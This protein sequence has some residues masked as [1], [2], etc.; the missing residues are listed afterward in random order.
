MGFASE[1][2]IHTLYSLKST[3]EAALATLKRENEQLRVAAS[4][5]GHRLKNVVAVIQS[6]ARQTIRQSTTMDDFEA[7]F[8]G[9]LGAFGRSLDL[10]IANDWHGARLD[11]LVRLELATF[12]SLAG[13]QISV[14]GPPLHLKPEA[15]R[16]I[17]LALHELA[18]NATKYGAL[19]VPEGK[20]A[21]QWKLA[22][23]GSHRRLLMTWQESGG[24]I[25]T[26]PTRW[27]F[28]RQV[29][30]QI[31]AQALT[32]NVTH[33]FLPHG[34]R[35]ALDI[36]VTFVIDARSKSANVS[37]YIG[38]TRNEMDQHVSQ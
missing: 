27:G 21:V 24:P 30:Q 19:S 23:N 31:P 12:G 34:V 20:V 8:S 29:I 37:P 16:S 13:A 26:E 28:G 11:E 10:L 22:G 1:A 14:K 15:A 25:V 4:E 6:L 5:L 38:S 17:G 7:R 2:N 18:T 3:T 9:R 36:P 32:G 33:Q 35:W